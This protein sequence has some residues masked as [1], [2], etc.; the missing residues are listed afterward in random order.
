MCLKRFHGMTL[1]DA[2]VPLQRD[3]C[4]PF[5]AFRSRSRSCRPFT[6]QR[7]SLRR[8]KSRGPWRHRRDCTT[9]LTASPK[10]MRC[11]PANPFCSLCETLR[12]TTPRD[13]VMTWSLTERDKRRTTSAFAFAK[14]NRSIATAP[15]QIPNDPYPTPP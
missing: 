5:S 4:A 12:L 6:E 15:F 8:C 10:W 2:S 9:L 13:A 7:L 14:A 11:Q 3:A 1:H